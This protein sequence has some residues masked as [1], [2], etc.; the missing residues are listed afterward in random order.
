MFAESP[1]DAADR[2][3][4]LWKDYR[5]RH[6]S[7]LPAYTVYG[8]GLYFELDEDRLRAWERQPEV[9]SRIDRLAVRYHAKC[10]TRRLEDREITPRLV[11]LH[12]LAHLLINRLSFECGY[13]AASLRERL[14]ISQDPDEPMAGMLIYTA[15]GDSEGT[16][17]GLVR[18]GKPGNLEAVLRHAIGGARWCSADPVC[19]EIGESGGQGP[20]SCNLAA[21]HSCALISETSCELHNRFLDRAVLTGSL[22]NPTI[23]Y[24]HRLASRLTP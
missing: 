10:R 24:F 17:G 16:L 20:D 11:M 14:Y 8:E 4:L 1:Y 21:C 15:A 13:S 2:Q 18:M 6:D 19:M 23:G 12:T 7:W 3:Y 22:D 9:A 5:Y